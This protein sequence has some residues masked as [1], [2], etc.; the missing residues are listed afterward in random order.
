M[1]VADAAPTARPASPGVLV[2][3][4]RA[5]LH[6]YRLIVS[7]LLGA[8]CRF[9]PSCSRYALEALTRHG[10]VRGNLL[11][12]ARLLRCAPWG[13]GGYDPV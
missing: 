8:N 7:P 1:A 5:L 12:L 4:E 9:S 6:G 3:L 13:R 10:F 11:A 2:R